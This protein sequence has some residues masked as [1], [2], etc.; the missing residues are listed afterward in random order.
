VNNFGAKTSIKGKRIT[1]SSNSFGKYKIKKFS[2]C[3]SL[4]ESFFSEKLANQIGIY[5]VKIKLYLLF[6]A[7]FYLNFY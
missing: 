4:I 5:F 1:V 7:C 3:I 2:C 6:E